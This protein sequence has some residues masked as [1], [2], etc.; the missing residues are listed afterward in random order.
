MDYVVKAGERS[1]KVIIPSS[2]SYAHRNLIC[3]ALSGEKSSLFCDGLSNDI[4][5]TIDCLR[6]LGSEIETDDN[7][8]IL[9]EPVSKAENTV[10]RLPCKE[11]GSTLRFLVPIA[12]ALG[13]NA[14]F[15]MAPGLAVRPMDVLIS[16]LEAHGVSVIRSGNEIAVSGR[17]QAGKYEIPGNISSQY[18]SGL[19]FALPLLDGSSELHITEKLESGAYIT[20]TE[21]IIRKA[22]I[23]LDKTDY[24][25]HIP[26][27]QHYRQDT[28]VSVEKDWSNAAFFLCMGALSDKGITVKGMNMESYQGDREIMHIL[29]G[30]GAEISYSGDEITVKKGCMKG[31]TVDASEVPD[32]VPAI[33]ALASCIEGT[34]EIVN[35]GRLRFKESDRLKSTTAMLKNIGADVTELESGLVIHGK[36]GL[37]GGNIN[38]END[39]RIAMA[40]AVAASVCRHDVT[41]SDAECVGKSFPKF[42]EYL[43]EMEIL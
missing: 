20:M 15:E 26:G 5:A 1:G 8:C 25:Y 39:H 7:G 6:Q 27:N 19:L 38:P 36:A 17:L 4:I 41:V 10:K 21:D 13:I 9:V 22:G 14:V 2:K 32:L 30:F 3:A 33:S 34:T 29:R 16:A 31:Q 42:W 37:E 24:G 43:E 35:A 28:C 23:V 12:S 11:S 40:A 18:I